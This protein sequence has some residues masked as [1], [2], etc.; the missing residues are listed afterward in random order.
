MA[1]KKTTEDPA[2]VDPLVEEAQS[3]VKPLEVVAE[4]APELEAAPAKITDK[5]LLGEV[6]TALSSWFD[7]GVELPK[8]LALKRKVEAHLG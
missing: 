8:I 2:L 4:V 6:L 1:K 5:E 3:A 7:G